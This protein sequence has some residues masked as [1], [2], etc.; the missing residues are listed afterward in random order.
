M[1]DDR[2]RGGGDVEPKKQH[3]TTQRACGERVGRVD[4]C[5][6]TLNGT[7]YAMWRRANAAKT[8]ASRY[9]N[10]AR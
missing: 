9:D 7:E 10:G 4:A 5:K 3:N 1:V 6:E 2:A 8:I